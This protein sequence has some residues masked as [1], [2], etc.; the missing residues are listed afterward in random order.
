MDFT[1]R[2]KNQKGTSTLEL[3]VVLPSLLF[4]LF[5]IIEFSRAWL[6]V[7]IVTTASRE[8]AR[9]G[10]VTPPL[11]GDVFDSAP[12][13]ARIDQILTAANLSTGVVRSVTCP[14][15][16]VTGSQVQADVQVTFDTLLPIILPMLADI[17]INRSTTMRFE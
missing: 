4:I 16:C 15:P 8:G 10:S 11:V 1:G 14:Q 7:N 9:T 13:E 12:A 3:V 2:Q 5:G 17:D 6:T